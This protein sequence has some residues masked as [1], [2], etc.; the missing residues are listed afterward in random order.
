M[1]FLHLG[2]QA[3]QH[4]D[5]L[6]FVRLFDFHHLEAAG[7]GGILF[8]VLL[9]LGPGG[10]RDGAQ[11]AARQGRLEQVGRIIL[12][13]LAARANQGVRFVDE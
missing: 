3:T 12:P 6:V 1:V 11:F 8:E 13:G 10:R 4:V 7:Q 2:Q 9:V 5:R